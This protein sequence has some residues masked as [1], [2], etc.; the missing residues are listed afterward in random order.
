M[1]TFRFAH[2]QPNGDHPTRA[3]AV[4]TTLH[5]ALLKTLRIHG[6]DLHGS[7]AF[8]GD[9]WNRI[10][11]VDIPHGGGRIDI[12]GAYS[13]RVKRGHVSQNKGWGTAELFNQKPTFS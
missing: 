3:V 13:F 8:E 4:G 7:T 5:D 9:N 12:G 10:G 1:A 6:R 2:P 11:V